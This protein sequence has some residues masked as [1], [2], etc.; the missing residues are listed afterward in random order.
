MVPDTIISPER[1]RSTTRSGVRGQRRNNIRDRETDG[2]WGD[3]ISN[4]EEG[5]FRIATHNI[6]GLP[7]NLKGEKHGQIIRMIKEQKIDYYGMSEINLN[8]P[9]ISRREQ[10]KCRFPGKIH[11]AFA[12][13]KHSTS[14][15]KQMYGGNGCL[16]STNATHRC[17]SSETDPT[18]LGRWI[19]TTLQGK[20]GMRLKIINGYRPIQDRSNRPGSVY[21][22]HEKYFNSQGQSR[23]PRKAFL[24]DLEKDIKRW[25]E[26][27]EQIILCLDLNEDSW[28]SIAA[29]RIISWGLHNVMTK[30]HPELQK[31]A[32]CNKNANNKPVDGIWASAG[33]EISSAGMSGFSELDVGK[34]DHRM[35]WMDVE[36]DSIFGIRPPKPAARPKNS[37]PLK[38]P[39]KLQKINQYIH[40]ERLRHNIP[41]KIFALE[42]RAQTQSFTIQDQIEYEK[43]HQLDFGIR[44]KA[45]KKCVKFY[46]GNIPFSPEIGKDRQEIHLWNMIL[47][48]LAKRRVDVKKIR[49]LMKKTEQRTALRMTWDEATQAQA[50]C[51]M[52][53]KQH[54]KQASDLRKK[55]E[56]K[57]CERR[58]RKFKTTIEVQT[59]L[60]RSTRQQKSIYARI[61]RVLDRKPFVALTTVTYE[62]ELNAQQECFTQPEVEQACMNEGRA[63]YTQTEGTPFRKGSLLEDIGLLA[64][65][66]KANQILDGTYHCADDVDEYTKKLIAQ[67]KKPN[68]IE[69]NHITGKTSTQ[70]HIAGWKKMKS[71]TSSSLFGPSFTE[72]IGACE[73]PRVAEVDAAFSNIPLYT[74]FCPLAWS[75]AID[76]MIPK[77]VSS[78]EVAKLRIIVL[79]DAMF[80]MLNKTIG[81]EMLAY[82]EDNGLIPNEVYGSRKGHRA[83]DCALNKVLANDVIRQKA[84]LAA[85]C[86]NDAASCYDRIVHAVAALCMRRLGVSSD[87]CHVMFGTIQQVEHYVSTAY[88]CSK[89]S[90][91]AMEFPLQGVL[92]GNGAGPAIWLVTSVPIINLLREQG[93]GFKSTNAI[94]KDSYQIVCFTF[95]DD[96]DTMHCPTDKDA[97]PSTL[98]REMQE[99]LHNWEGGLH[100]TGGALSHKK[101]YWYSIS[102]KWNKKKM[103]WEYETID[104]TPGE[105]SIQDPDGAPGDQKA[106]TRL[107]VNQ[108]RETLGLW[109]AMNGDQTQQKQALKEKIEKWA[110]KIKTKQ[111]TTTEAWLSLQGGIAKGIGYPVAATCLS[112]RDCQDIMK[113]L[114]HVALPSIGVPSKFPRKLVHAPTQYFGQGIPHIWNEQ[115]EAI[116]GACLRHGQQKS[117]DSTSML[118]RDIMASMRIELGLPSHPF[119]YPFKK[120]QLCTTETYLHTAWE[121]CNDNDLELRDD[122]EDWKANRVGDEFLMLRFLEEGYNPKEL[123]LLNLCRKTTRTILISDLTTGDGL[124][125]QQ[126]WHLPSF[127]GQDNH[128][129]DWPRLGPL[130]KTCWKLWE[131]AIQKCFVKPDELHT[132]TLKQ[133]LGNWTQQPTAWRWFLTE[134]KDCLYH[135]QGHNTADRY[136]SNTQGIHTRRPCFTL[137]DKQI[138]VSK[139]L[140]HFPTSI[141]TNRS[142]VYHTGACPVDVTTHIPT[143]NEWWKREYQAPD[144]VEAIL[145]GIRDGTAIC[146]TDGSFKNNRGT[147]AYV[148]KASIDTY[149]E[150]IYVNHTPGSTNIQDP[151]RAELSGIYGSLKVMTDLAIKHKITGSAT[152]GCDCQAALKNVFEYDTVKP[153]QPHADLVFE[154]QQLIKKS[155]IAWAGRYV[156]AHQDEKRSWNDLDEWEQLNCKMD[157]LAKIYWQIT[158]DSDLS[159]FDLPASEV[160]SLWH[161]GHRLPSWNHQVA[162][163]VIYGKHSRQYWH[164]RHRRQFQSHPIIDWD[165]IQRAVQNLPFHQRTWHSKW[166]ASYIPIGAKLQLWKI[167]SNQ[168][169]P[170][171]GN[172][173]DHKSHVLRCPEFEATKLWKANMQKLEQW[174][175]KSYTSPDIQ[176]VIKEAL[177]QWYEKT[178]FVPPTVHWTQVNEL[179]TA[180][181]EIGWQP[182]LDGFLSTLWES[183]QQQYYEWIRKRYTGR[184]WVTKLLR[185]L[186]S[187]SWQMWRHRQAINEQP[188]SKTMVA[189][190]AELDTQIDAEYNFFSTNPSPH[191]QRWFS[192]S[193][194]TLYQDDE[195]GKKQWLE[196]VQAARHAQE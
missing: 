28:N 23:E 155:P 159:T 59:K 2:P 88:G 46:A 70:N 60:I 189:I 156:P 139:E 140:L 148:C 29:E 175:V 6:Q 135:M 178:D 123:R 10:W 65:T 181:Q 7:V 68:A 43:L 26:Q 56:K 170:R 125:L 20:Q 79:F 27:G 90:Y 158:D 100:A 102:F 137:Q 54:K 72:L 74:G 62:D 48:K 80:N 39:I 97:T 142:K 105:I 16:L 163:D 130:T 110:S 120:L 96:T 143:N 176:L 93:F 166:A 153:G 161:Q 75:K 66:E 78:K 134:N 69:L 164:K 44:T 152:L 122:M 45:R 195:D 71:T 49:R 119:H 169:C 15:K 185:Q 167:Q 21:S 187:I 57:L 95:V 5:T 126:G 111:L 190:H 67:M 171:C 107:E 35:L 61:R 146:V 89:D 117:S 150:A 128:N 104:E 184:R 116:L 165:C 92:Q 101:C 113:P 4:K 12:Y 52:Q 124:R 180:Q 87:A 133:P 85:L 91:Q 63:R 131:S 25:A 50:K 94:T 182:F 81:R 17:E 127:Q 108:A 3:N 98:L 191:L 84:L 38:D 192:Q 77:K 51:W 37:I 193:I 55:F 177:R 162:M 154:V 11:T 14:K 183:T 160:W 83:V 186:W 103:E 145:A 109:V 24:D 34:T 196:A 151:Y 121:F 64:D 8:L 115:G 99:V 47:T 157:S 129:L 30:I 58:A 138:Q 188:T 31:V 73:D 22:Q 106:I 53:Y 114:L 112:K 18:E 41:Q 174:M 173:E 9:N 132:Q 141:T 76:V 86:S 194:D 36:M 1:P 168:I 42:A 82:A 136:T 19:V 13:N 172:D 118:L 33:I 179:I 144:D 149:D 147:A 40:K 32:T